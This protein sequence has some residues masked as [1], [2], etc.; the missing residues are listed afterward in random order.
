MSLGKSSINGPCSMAMLNNQ[1]VTMDVLGYNSDLVP[2]YYSLYPL[3]HQLHCV[4]GWQLQL[5][6]YKLHNLNYS[7]ILY[8]VNPGT[9][10]P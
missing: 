3:V 9:T 8:N 10:K 4:D 5:T 2:H 1:R 7:H 6:S